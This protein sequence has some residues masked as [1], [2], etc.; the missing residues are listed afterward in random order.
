MRCL[1]TSLVIMLVTLLATGVSVYARPQVELKAEA[2]V[3]GENVL[4]GEIATISGDSELVSTLEEVVV[5]TAPLAGYARRLTKGHIEVRLR[6]AGI[7]PR[8]LEFAGASNIQIVREVEKVEPVEEKPELAADSSLLDTESPQV[9]QVA[10]VTTRN[11]ARGEVLGESDL[12]LM[13]LERRRVAG[14]PGE[15]SDYV[16]LQAVRNLSEGSVVTSNA[17]AA[18]IVVQRGDRIQIIARVG[19]IEV[20]SAGVARESGALGDIILVENT[21][22]RKRLSAQI[23]DSDTVNANILGV[24]SP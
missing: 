11:V 10:V 15:I 4:L 2:Q 8:E 6:Q 9:A 1:K 17:V 24:D 13:E 3:S 23:L 22:S 16:G 14:D 20:R 19:A 18:P 7:S 5:A 21:T 12:N